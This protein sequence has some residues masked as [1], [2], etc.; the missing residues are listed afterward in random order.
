MGLELKL[1]NYG[2]RKPFQTLK[3]QRGC[4][5]DGTAT[6]DLADGTAQKQQQTWKS[7]NTVRHGSHQ[8]RSLQ[9]GLVE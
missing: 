4:F 9:D 7:D 3:K 6:E 1:K 8:D 5:A 2:E